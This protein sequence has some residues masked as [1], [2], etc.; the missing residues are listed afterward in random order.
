MCGDVGGDSVMDSDVAVGVCSVGT[1]KGVILLFNG[2]ELRRFFG[3]LLLS[4]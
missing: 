2:C 4:Q 1:N 3:L